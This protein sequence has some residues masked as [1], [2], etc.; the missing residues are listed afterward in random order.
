M[1]FVFSSRILG[2][3][4]LFL[5]AFLGLL[6]WIVRTGR[7]EVSAADR[8]YMQGQ[9]SQGYV[10]V[11]NTV[12]AIANQLEEISPRPDR[13]KIAIFCDRDSWERQ[14]NA[15]GSAQSLD[16]N[17]LVDVPNGSILF[18]A[19]GFEP[20]NDGNKRKILWAMA[21]LS[22]RSDD[23]KRVEAFVARWTNELKSSGDLMPILLVLSMMIGSFQV[24]AKGSGP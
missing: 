12:V 17:Y 10:E 23:P 1:R 13:P 19:Q 2:R 24:G 3:L 7:K 11:T 14:R 20:L 21:E 15:I 4:S 5:I 22:L 18:N 9:I 8:K 16:T 6:L